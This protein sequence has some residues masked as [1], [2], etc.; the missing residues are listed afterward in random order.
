MIPA[1]SP[2]LKIPFPKTKIDDKCIH[3][4]HHSLSGLTKY[5]TE[6]PQG[7]LQKTDCVSADHV[8]ETR[9]PTLFREILSLRTAHA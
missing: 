4:Q 7:L 5:E 1:L 2:L 3:D 8:S 9:G 6:G